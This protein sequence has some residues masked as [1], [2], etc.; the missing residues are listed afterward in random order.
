MSVFFDQIAAEFDQLETQV[1]DK[2]LYTYDMNILEH[3]GLN[4][5]G[6]AS[7]GRS[8]FA[9]VA[10]RLEFMFSR[11]QLSGSKESILTV[12]SVGLTFY[13]TPKP[14]PYLIKVAGMKEA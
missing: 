10:R 7:P 12:P 8:I 1:A 11:D 13:D 5:E 6:S 9:F 3:I 2:M 14:R 4:F